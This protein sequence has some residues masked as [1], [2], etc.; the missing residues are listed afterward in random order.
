MAFL[1]LVGQALEAAGHGVATGATALAD[2]ATGGLVPELRGARC[3][4]ERR[5]HNAARRAVENARIVS[6]DVDR[7]LGT[8][9]ESVQALTHIIA[10]PEQSRR[11]GELIETHDFVA[12][13]RALQHGARFPDDFFPNW[14]RRAGGYFPKFAQVLSVRA[15]LIHNRNVLDQL[16]RC[17]EDMPSRSSE[18]VREHLLS[19]GWSGR[20]CE[21]LGEALNAG[22]VAQ[23]NAVTLPDGSL[24]VVKVAWPDTKRQMQTDFRLFHHAR[25]ILSALR[26]EDDTAQTVGALFSA[27]SKNEA[28]VMREFDMQAESRVLAAAGHLCAAEWPTAYN[29]WLVAAP[30]LLQGLPPNLA[31]LVSAWTL[32]LQ[33]PS[34]SVCVQVPEPLPQL[35]S[36]SVLAMSRA[37]GMS[38]HQLLRGDRGDAGRQEAAGVLIGLAIPFIGWMLLCK[39]TSHFG[40]VDPHPGNLRWCS[41]SR[42]L[43]V[44]DWGSNVTLAAGRR[45]ALCMLIALAAADAEAGALADA[46]RAFGLRSRDDAKLARLVRGVLNATTAHGAQD[47]INTAA[48]DNILDEVG[49]D[50]VPVVRCLATLGGLLKELQ[51]QIRDEHQHDVPLSLAALWEPFAA[52]GLGV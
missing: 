15:D 11:L 37:G 3:D 27:V 28:A 23:V 4:Q 22:T 33:T 49:A 52:R 44:L 13:I 2:E 42:V 47:A 32:Q 30:M 45:S 19:Q 16:A 10:N 43:W 51:R 35:C 21:G 26:L 9:R 6:V 34:R 50:V 12:L 31:V 18:R 17:L 40:H 8:T 48:I 36:D 46:A 29:G 41:V 24:A 7:V 25:S 39:S 5:M 1:R 20:A 14:I 38:M